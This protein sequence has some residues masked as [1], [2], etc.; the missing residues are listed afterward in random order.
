MAFTLGRQ[1]RMLKSSDFRRALKQGRRLRFSHLTVVIF[2]RQY[3]KVRL[4]LTV[5]KKIGNAVVRNRLKRRLRE[6][7]R[8]KRSGLVR[9][10]DVLILAQDGSGDLSSRALVDELE[11]AFRELNRLEKSAA[12]GQRTGSD[13]GAGPDRQTRT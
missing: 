3:G 6:I 5:S 9:P 12:G 11:P 4:G 7:I 2:L 8:V 13:P 1:E 10:W